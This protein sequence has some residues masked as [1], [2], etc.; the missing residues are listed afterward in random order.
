MAAEDSKLQPR[1]LPIFR[2]AALHD[3]RS[4]RLAKLRG[5]PTDARISLELSIHSLDDPPEYMALSYTWGPPYQE[6]GIPTV[7]NTNPAPEEILCNGCLFWISQNLRDALTTIPPTFLQGFFWIDQLCIDQTNDEEKSSQVTLMGEIYEMTSVVL[8]WLGPT[9]SE[10]NLLYWAVE[11]F[12]PALSAAFDRDRQQISSIVGPFDP[13]LYTLLSIGEANLVRQKLTQFIGFVQSIRYFT[14]IWVMQEVALSSRVRTFCGPDHLNLLELLDLWSYIASNGWVAHLADKGSAIPSFHQMRLLDSSTV[15]FTLDD[16]VEKSSDLSDNELHFWKNLKSQLKCFTIS[17]DPLSVSYAWLL[18]SLCAT[19]QF[20]C[21]DSR[22]KIYSV[23]SLINPELKRKRQPAILSD[24]RL[25]AEDVYKSAMASIF[26]NTGLLD[27][28]GMVEDRQP[29]TL[30]EN[31]PS[32]VPDFRVQLGVRT[33][34]WTWDEVLDGHPFD[35]SRCGIT[36]KQYYSVC[37]SVLNCQGHEKFRI[38]HCFGED[39]QSVAES[40]RF[41]D[42]LKFGQTLSRG[43]DTGLRFEVFWRTLIMD[44]ARNGQIPAPEEMGK[45]FAQFVAW[46]CASKF[47]RLVSAEHEL[48]ELAV[49]FSIVNS[50][51]QPANHLNLGDVLTWIDA[52]KTG[53]AASGTAF[54]EAL[55][56]VSILDSLSADYRQAFIRAAPGRQ[57]MVTADGRLVIGALSARPGDEVWV[58][59]NARVLHILRPQTDSRNEYRY[60]GE[61]YIHG[62]MHG[63]LVEEPN[64]PE[65]LFQKISIV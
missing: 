25:T 11:E 23:I 58:L 48:E 55:T 39:I 41:S 20:S 17:F 34:L 59:R 45:Q 21:S 13:R 4:F 53:H 43:L 12:G 2:H 18:R 6:P 63:E 40:F 38:E 14:R 16:K 64:G 15:W 60:I 29:E 26:L 33:A 54:T 57:L 1:G 30:P 49:L 52:F 24:Y 22:D 36:H 61:C 44:M 42:L 46:N 27:A 7:D 56:K 31:Y 28:L 3:A 50:D 65:G 47:Q 5:S 62:C 19:R 8:V 51:L 32:W 10:S 35:V 9:T 37:G